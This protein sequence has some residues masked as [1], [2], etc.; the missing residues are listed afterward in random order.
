[1]KEKGKFPFFRKFEEKGIFTFFKNREILKEKGLLPFS[2][3]RRKI[4]L[5]KGFHFPF[6]KRRFSGAKCKKWKLKNHVKTVDIT[7]METDSV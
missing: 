1:M 6:S 5:K 3:K 2:R 7:V 4:A